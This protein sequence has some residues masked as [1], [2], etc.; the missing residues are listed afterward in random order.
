MNSTY[1]IYA[2]IPIISAMIGWVTNYIAVKM[3]FRP[4]QPLNILGFKIQG[5]IPRRQHELALNLGDL[6]EKELVSHKDVHEIL[7]SEEVKKEIT[8][9][10]ENQV[11]KFMEDKLGSI[12]M[13]SMFLQGELAHQIKSMAVAQLNTV[14]PEF[15]DTCMKHVE[16]RLDFKEIVREKVENFDHDMLEKMVF[17]IAAKE[18]KTIELLGAILGFLVGVTQVAL[19]I[20]VSGR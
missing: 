17:R 4:R 12:P 10:L 19:L 2:L 6:V 16:E 3:I 15:L 1:V 13:I 11:D 18:L 7:E 8:H 5:L 20:V 14:I 9:Q